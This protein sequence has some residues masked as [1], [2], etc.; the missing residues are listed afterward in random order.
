M[1]NS[2][3]FFS[4]RDFLR[5]YSAHPVSFTPG[6]ESHGYNDAPGNIKMSSGDESGE[7]EFEGFDPDDLLVQGNV[8]RTLELKITNIRSANFLE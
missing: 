5:D 3:Y 7:S 1:A 2:R 8:D 4:A 6:I